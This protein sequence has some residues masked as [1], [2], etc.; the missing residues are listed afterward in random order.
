VFLSSC[1]EKKTQVE[2]PDTISWSQ[3]ETVVENV[4]ES[5]TWVV[6]PWQESL[7]ILEAESNISN[8][9]QTV[10]STWITQ[11]TLNHQEIIEQTEEDLEALFNSFY[12]T[13]E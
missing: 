13:S 1:F 10:T 12:E 3:A 9:S 4:Q 2:I 5:I 11:D 6:T 7:D 8:D